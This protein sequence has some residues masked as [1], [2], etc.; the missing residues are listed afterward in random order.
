MSYNDGLVQL[1]DVV[2]RSFVLHEEVDD[3]GKGGGY[4][5]AESLKNG[6]SGESLACGNIYAKPAG[7]RRV[8]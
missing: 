3:L 5:F 6:N 2:G 4:Q 1:S 8:E 7:V